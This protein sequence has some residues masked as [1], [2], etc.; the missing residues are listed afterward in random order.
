M[1]SNG[2]RSTGIAFWVLLVL[3]GIA[4]CAP[5]A[6]PPTQHAAISPD[7]VKIYTRRPSRYEALP[8]ISA[9]VT[10]EMKWDEN[11]DSNAAFDALKVKA[12]AR[13]ANGVLLEPEKGKHDLLVTVAYHG[14]WYQLPAKRDPKEVLGRAIWVAEE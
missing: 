11:G 12:A 10:S 2:R 3:G 9:P 4:G 7:Q 14:T 1:D 6:L 5:E 13:G 8:V